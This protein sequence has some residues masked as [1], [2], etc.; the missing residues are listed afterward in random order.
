M[1]IT[2]NKDEFKLKSH[3]KNV[4]AVD[5]PTIGCITCIK[6]SFIIDLDAQCSLLSGDE[7]NT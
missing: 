5:F 4:T 6:L 3:Q 7:C 2:E 1:D